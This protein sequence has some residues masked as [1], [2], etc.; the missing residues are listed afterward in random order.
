MK[1]NIV[2]D[3]SFRFALRAIALAKLLR[4]THEFDL[5][6]QLLRAGTSVGA[7]IEEAQAAVSRADFVAKM[8]V[9][10]KEARES[11]YWLRLLLAAGLT[12]VEG[13]LALREIEEL[14][15]LLTSIVKT[16]QT[17]R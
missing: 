14:I 9:A 17:R 2:R 3:K 5:A 12:G 16:G 6:R 10:S 13:E 1:T 7:N 4:R 11:R 15:R 8:G